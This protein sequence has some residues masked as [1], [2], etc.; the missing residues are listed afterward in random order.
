M[1]ILNPGNSKHHLFSYHEVRK[2]LI[3]IYGKPKNDEDHIF[4]QNEVI[5][6]RKRMKLYGLLEDFHKEIHK[7]WG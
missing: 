4:L 1:K 2:R 3:E 7:N 6:F 5:A